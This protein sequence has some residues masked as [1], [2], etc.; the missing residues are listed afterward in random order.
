ML[1]G[2]EM[3]VNVELTVISVVIT[4]IQ[5][6]IWLN[7]FVLQMLQTLSLS[8]QFAAARQQFLN[9][10]PFRKDTDLCA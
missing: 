6:Q 4:R 10:I 7:G 2:W 3:W 1:M 9:L 8:I 5:N